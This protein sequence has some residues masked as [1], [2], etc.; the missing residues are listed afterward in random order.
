MVIERFA[1]KG[2]G[3]AGSAV[4]GGIGGFLSSPFGLGALGLGAIVITLFLFRDRIGEF[5]SG[6][7]LPEIDLPDI[8]LP[9]LPDIT[10]P[11]FEFP[12]FEFPSFDFDFPEITF[13]TF[14]F[15]QLPDIFNIFGNGEPDEP[16]E[17][18]PEVTAAIEEFGN[19][20]LMIVQDAEGNVTVTQTTPTPAAPFRDAERFARDFP[21]EFRPQPSRISDILNQVIRPPISS[22]FPDQEFT[23]GGVSFIG[24]SV[25]ET[26]ISQ[27]SLSQ[28]IDKFNVS[29]SQA[30]DIRA[31]ARN[32]FG[33][34]DFGSN[35]GSGIGSIFQDPALTT[36][37]PSPNVS[38][39]SLQGLTAREISRLIT[40]GLLEPQ[41]LS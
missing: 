6:L 10:F 9:S 1:K 40:R 35:T 8:N 25:T 21:E 19:E 27:L 32:D 30:A 7:K 4:G 3:I 20:N 15:P 17:T 39:P 37:I 12:T 2:A 34:F 24:G 26:P 13:P 41:F 22:D 38:D 18:S 36:F 11:T 16:I 14:E 29:A 5:F 23:G 33:D 31:R 28:I